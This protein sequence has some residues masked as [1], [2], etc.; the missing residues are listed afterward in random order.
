MNQERKAQLEEEEKERQRLEEEKEKER[1][2]LEAEKA[3]KERLQKEYQEKMQKF[4]DA[5]LKLKTQSQALLMIDQPSKAD[6]E[7]MIETSN[8]CQKLVT[9]EDFFALSPYKDPGYAQFR[10]R[11]VQYAKNL[12]VKAKPGLTKDLQQVLDPQIQKIQTSDLMMKLMTHNFGK[13]E[14]S[15]PLKL[16]AKELKQLARDRELIQKLKNSKENQLLIQMADFGFDKLC[17]ILLDNIK[18][19]GALPDGK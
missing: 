2:R 17:D 14:G 13:K 16:N 4:H 11:V 3:E 9:S 19:S 6:L 10:T 12:E 1:Q 7:L 8:K 15:A 18:K 5:F